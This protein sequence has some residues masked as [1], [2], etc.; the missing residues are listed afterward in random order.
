MRDNFLTETLVTCGQRTRRIAKNLCEL[1]DPSGGEHKQQRSAPFKGRY[2][3]GVTRL[4][5]NS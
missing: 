5:S 2:R 4:N 3:L 1:E